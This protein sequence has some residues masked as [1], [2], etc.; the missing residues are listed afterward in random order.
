MIEAEARALLYRFWASRYGSRDGRGDNTVT[1]EQ[2]TSGTSPLDPSL[3]GAV[4]E[5]V[6]REPGRVDA[7]FGWLNGTAVPGGVTARL[8]EAMTAQSLEYFKKV[9]DVEVT[10][11]SNLEQLASRRGVP[12]AELFPGPFAES[13][14]AWTDT[15][16]LGVEVSADHT[17]PFSRTR[18]RA[19]PGKYYRFGADGTLEVE[20]DPVLRIIDETASFLSALAG[21]TERT[22]AVK[23]LAADE[24]LKTANPVLRRIR[25]V[26]TV[27]KDYRVRFNAAQGRTQVQEEEWIMFRYEHE[28]GVVST[29]FRVERKARFDS[30]VG[31]IPSVGPLAYAWRFD[32]DTAVDEEG[33]ERDTL[34]RGILI[35]G[36][37]ANQPV[38]DPQSGQTLA[39]YGGMVLPISLRG[40]VRTIWADI[41]RRNRGR[42]DWDLNN[43]WTYF[44]EVPYTG[45]GIENLTSSEKTK[46][47]HMASGFYLSH[48]MIESGF[49]G[50]GNLSSRLTQELQ[51]AGLLAAFLEGRSNPDFVR[52]EQ[53]VLDRYASQDV[54]GHVAFTRYGRTLSVDEFRELMAFGMEAGGMGLLTGLYGY[55]DAFE[56]HSDNLFKT[57]GQWMQGDWQWLHSAWLGLDIRGTKRLPGAMPG[58]IPSNRRTLDRKVVLR[59]AEMEVLYVGQEYQQNPLND[60][61]KSFI[62]KT[63]EE[64]QR[65]AVGFLWICGTLILA[66]LNG[67]I[68]TP[69]NAAVFAILSLVLPL[70]AQIGIMK[71]G[72]IFRETRQEGMTFR[73][74]AA[75][76]QAVIDLLI[77]VIIISGINMWKGFVNTLRLMYRAPSM[78][79]VTAAE[80]KQGG[81][82]INVLSRYFVGMLLGLSFVG[83]VIMFHPNWVWL[84]FGSVFLASLVIGPLFSYITSRPTSSGKWMIGVVV[85]L[86]ALALGEGHV[87]A[88]TLPDLTLQ[89]MRAG[90]FIGVSAL[91]GLTS[92][93][94]FYAFRVFYREMFQARVT[95]RRLGRGG[96]LWLWGVFSIPPS[97]V[98]ATA[99]KR[100]LEPV[101]R[102]VRKISFRSVSDYLVRGY[103]QTGVFSNRYKAL[104][105]LGLIIFLGIS[106]LAFPSLSMALAFKI[107]WVAVLLTAVYTGLFYPVGFWLVDR[108]LTPG[109]AGKWFNPMDYFRISFHVVSALAGNGI[110]LLVKL[111]K[112][113]TDLIRAPRDWGMI[114]AFLRK[115]AEPSPAEMAS[116][117]VL[118]GSASAELQKLTMKKLAVAPF[119][120]EKFRLL[121]NSGRMDEEVI[122]RLSETYFATRPQHAA[123]MR[124]EL[125]E[126][127]EALSSVN[128][129]LGIL[130]PLPVLREMAVYRDLQR[131]S[132]VLA[133]DARSI[134]EFSEA[135]R[136]EILNTVRMERAFVIIYNVSLVGKGLL[137]DF[138]KD[139][140]LRMIPE[141]IETL[142]LKLAS[143]K[144]VAFVFSDR[145][146]PSEEI[147]RIDGGMFRKK[148][149]LYRQIHGPEEGLIT[150][151]LLD[152]E[153]GDKY[154][155]FREV[156][157]VCELIDTA[158]LGVVQTF[159]AHELVSQSA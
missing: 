21:D 74:A 150:A 28:N 36:H 2:V 134:A 106:L 118:L 84:L 17:V 24:Y 159:L 101:I 60:V 130:T 102:A 141:G 79:W 142:P 3:A 98:F 61:Q 69:G 75:W 103:D 58:Y 66:A 140:H 139:S 15:R 20:E 109:R 122:D 4:A 132:S 125:R 1:G 71:F 90:R 54:P 34:N 42:V 11:G 93:G 153:Y 119:A 95:V 110:G 145:N 146:D 86:A 45:K 137:R 77:E 81:R 53:F 63:V 47:Q 31:H 133:V 26:G 50:P 154:H 78:K 105:N 88:H 135:Q 30:V 113:L 64:D 8:S 147:F 12:V 39:G 128:E 43:L 136:L 51:Q 80:A 29:F 99:L 7:L 156:K 59:G 111:V 121:V 44:R 124:S 107:P 97:S 41:E 116:I 76:G 155:I 19:V 127:L 104:G 70:G 55:E 126:P 33:E 131:L 158:L 120:D 108:V 18:D 83:L 152:L 52:A 16:I 138:P 112:V 115:N 46:S 56:N 65:P 100:N 148:T 73:N 5:A 14:H 72:K 87:L 91:G 49:L 85:V 37:P 35:A 129:G 23:K 94:L 32:N 151:A 6:D 89:L 68:F 149:A 38:T 48:D 27:K 10:P 144:K 123:P 157:G 25:E 96:A 57:Q 40:G 92:L 114:L 143:I 67:G 62:S 117:G 22:P 82:F 9:T 13:V